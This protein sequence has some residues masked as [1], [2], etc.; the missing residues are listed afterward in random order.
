MKDLRFVLSAIFK[1]RLFLAVLVISE[2]ASLSH[3]QLLSVDINGAARSDTTAPGFNKWDLPLSLSADSR[4]ATLSFTNYVYDNDPDTGLP[5]AT[6]IGSIIGCQLEQTFPTVADATIFLK[7]DYANKDGNTTSA[8]PNAG[9]RLA[10]DGC[11]VHWKDDAIPVDMPYTNGGAFRLTL[12]N[13]TAGVHTITTYHNDNFAR[14]PLVA[15]HA[16]N[17]MSRCI[18]SANGV[19]RFTNVPTFYATNDSKCGFAY[20]YV[21]NTYDGQPVVLD[22]TPDGSSPLNFVI[23]NGFEVDRPNPPGTTASAIFPLSGDDHALAN[24]DVPLPGTANA[25]YLTLKWLPASFAISNYLYFGTNPVSV[26]NATMASPE[27]K[28]L[29]AAVAGVTNSFNVSNLN[30]AATYYW[31]VDQLD[32]A[33]GATNLVNGAVWSFRPRHLAFPGAEGYGRFARGGRGGRVIEVTNLNDSGP[34]SYRAAVQASGP[35]TVVFRVS[36]IIWLQSDCV[37]GNGYLTVAG[38]TA[39]GDGICLANYRAGMTS[40]SDV[41]LRFMRCRLGDGARKAM[42]GIGLGNSTHS[43]IDHTTISWTMDEGT[44]SRQSGRVDSESAM[45]TF[46]R[47]VISE[48]LQHSYHYDGA[49]RTNYEPHAFAGSISGEIGSYHHNLLAH[50]TDRNWSLAGGLDQSQKYAGS[51][52]IRNNVVYNWA[53]RTTDGGVARCNYVNN[54]YKSYPTSPSAKFLLKLDTIQTNW[55]TEAYYMTGNVMTGVSGQADLFTNN[56]ANGGFVNGSTVEA[57]V[58]TNSEIFPSYVDTQSA[59]NTYKIVLSDS[60][61]NLPKPDGIDVRVVSEVLDRTIHYIGTNGDPYIIDGVSQPKASANIAGIIDSQ[62]DVKDYTNNPAA[63]N[64]SPNA[65]WPPYYTYNVPVDTD[66]DGLPDWWERIK[67]LNTNSSAGDFSDSNGDPDGDGYTHLE[68]YL[69]WLAKPHH[70]CTNGTTLNVELTPYTRGFTN[71]SPTYAVF[72]ATNGTVVL[73]SRT[74]QFNSTISTNGL[75]SFM[76]KVTDA[77]GFSY[78]NTV[79][80]RLVAASAP[81]NTAPEFAGS[82][83]NRV[84]NVG[85]NLLVTNAAT[86]ADVGQTL[87]YSLPVGPTNSTLNN[88][89]GVFS[90]RPLVTQA[91]TTNAVEVVVADDGS[92]SLSATQSF[93][94]IINPLT[95]P[96]FA[97]AQVL[98][99]QLGLS[100]SGQVGPNY[101]VQNSSNL[102]NWTTLLITNPTVMPFNWSTNTGALPSQFYRIKVGPPS[103]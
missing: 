40:C 47:N 79:N 90:W 12:L 75:G 102:V 38:Q 61:C 51:L 24:N 103:P 55:G 49:N 44:S 20:F 50:S 69:N 101:A 57:Q 88:S 2:F 32:V 13:L 97:A 98:N 83:S 48:P 10:M 29:S 87:T 54:F 67:G 5:I 80:V 81:A 93:S 42:D 68:D 94:V 77:S 72:G 82:A 78:T 7:A 99:G 1:C 34:G 60:G 91:N 43:I 18:I 73:S 27:F 59:S 21:T 16:G 58:R 8:D 31:R 53:G 19:P 39:P 52:D 86:D 30:S 89:N 85:V 65:P 4:S 100:V 96:R 95:S 63:P 92:P 66:H 35:R 11:R 6:N 62:N 64:Y 17:V 71:N 56:W 33:N 74:A 26:G 76:F 3:G 28:Q 14:S 45:I 36:G 23:L 25:G 22:F 84:I 37:V 46:Q 15:W 70:D 41:I 9:W